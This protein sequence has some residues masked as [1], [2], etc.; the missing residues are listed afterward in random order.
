M[1]FLF[2]RRNRLSCGDKRFESPA[3][4]HAPWQDPQAGLQPLK[5]VLL[6]IMPKRP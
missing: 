5:R 2:R 6:L 3:A 1:F 4:E